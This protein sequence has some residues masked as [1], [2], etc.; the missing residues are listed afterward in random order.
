MK[1]NFKPYLLH[2]MLQKRSNIVEKSNISVLRPLKITALCLWSYAA[3]SSP[4]LEST[5]TPTWTFDTHI[6]TWNLSGGAVLHRCIT[7]P[8]KS[9]TKAHDREGPPLGRGTCLLWLSGDRSRDR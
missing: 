4:K 8:L 2:K 3:N 1:F 7:T 9:P 5:P 6:L